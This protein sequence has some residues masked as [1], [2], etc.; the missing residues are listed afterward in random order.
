MSE[1]PYREPACQCRRHRWHGFDP[2][3]RK[4]PLEGN[5]HW[6]QYSCLGNPLDRGGCRTTVQG[7]QRVRHDWA[8]T[9]VLQDPISRSFWEGGK[10]LQS[11][12][13][14]LMGLT[15]CLHSHL[16]IHV[17]LALIFCWPD[18]YY[19]ISRLLVGLCF[20]PELSAGENH[21]MIVQKIFSMG[22][23]IPHPDPVRSHSLQ[24][25]TRVIRREKGTRGFWCT[26][27]IPV[28][29]RGP[30][31]QDHGSRRSKDCVVHIRRCGRFRS[32]LVSRKGQMQP[33]I[34]PE[35]VKGVAIGS[36]EG[37]CKGWSI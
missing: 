12:P 11:Y 37:G 6:L 7:L 22:Q 36:E 25:L 18:K 20:H 35:M 1:R 10:D 9:P 13:P 19:C 15:S 31:S 17:L 8:C 33:P 14:N 29:V 23:Q 2:W 16:W 28:L 5:S 34:V 32:S 24:M 3:V 30:G 4:I 21:Y 26:F 27:S